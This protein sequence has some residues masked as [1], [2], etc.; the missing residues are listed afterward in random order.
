MTARQTYIENMKLELDKLN[1]Q[2]G[3]LEDRATHAKLRAR[4]HYE[5][6]LNEL[7]GRSR[8]ALKKWDE[9][10]ASGEATWHQWTSDMERLRDA[11][12]RSFQEIK[13][14]VLGTHEKSDEIQ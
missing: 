10:N 5:A 4:E 13:L 2:L 3:Y 6:E 1:D 11:F 12:V 7:R 14:R 8:D 9:L